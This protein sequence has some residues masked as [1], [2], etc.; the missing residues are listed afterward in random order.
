MGQGE[1]DGR[2]KVK[3]GRMFLPKTVRVEVLRQ[4]WEVK[5]CRGNE[6]VRG[7]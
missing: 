5:R 4:E 7:V 2:R 6:R 3:T 1:K